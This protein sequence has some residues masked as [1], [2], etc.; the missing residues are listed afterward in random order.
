VNPKHWDIQQQMNHPGGTPAP[1]SDSEDWQI[2][3]ILIEKPSA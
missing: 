1:S 3:S 2:S